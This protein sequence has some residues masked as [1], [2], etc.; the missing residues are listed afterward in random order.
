MIINLTFFVQIIHF[1]I[2]YLI[3][4]K[5]IFGP[6]LNLIEKE[7]KTKL[8]FDE[9]ILEL[10]NLIEIKKEAKE[11]S[12]KNFNFNMNNY[13][14]NKLN[15]LKIPDVFLSSELSNKFSDSIKNLEHNIVNI[16]KG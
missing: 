12:W 1:F 13:L 15:H 11:L 16:L 4:K 10:T 8:I 5:Y 9:K 7:N 3:S 2:G 6:V 14:A